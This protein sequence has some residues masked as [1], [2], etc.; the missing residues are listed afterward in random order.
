MLSHLPI[1]AHTLTWLIIAH[2]CTT[3][4]PSSS[5]LLKHTPHTT[6]V[7]VFFFIRRGLSMLLQ[8]ISHIP[9]SIVYLPSV[10]SP[11]CSPLLHPNVCSLQC[12]QV[13]V[14]IVR[15]FEVWC[16]HPSNP[17]VSVISRLP[18]LLTSSFHWTA[19]FNWILS[20][21]SIPLTLLF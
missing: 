2:T 1:T 7:S 13:D 16:L 21:T 6:P 8:R 19:Y 3:W 9:I 14:S 12:L 17:R 11:A 18:S 10:S 4:A 15:H 20:F 5:C